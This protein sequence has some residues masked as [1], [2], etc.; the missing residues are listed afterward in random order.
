MRY[1]LPDDEAGMGATRAIRMTAMLC[2]AVLAGCG[3]AAQAPA[4]YGYGD[5]F[6]AG[7]D[8]MGGL[9]GG[10]PPSG[11]GGGYPS[12][13]EA[14]AAPAPTAEVYDEEGAPAY[15]PDAERV[16]MAESIDA[17]ASAPARESRRGRS[18]AQRSAAAPP[19]PAPSMAASTPAPAQPPAPPSD[20]SAPAGGPAT[21]EPEEPDEGEAADEGPMLIYEAALVL[22]TNEASERIDEVGRL[23]HEMGGFLVR[24]DDRSI[25]VRVPAG[26][27]REALAA[28]EALG[29]VLDRSVSALDVSEQVRDTRVRLQNAINL[30][31]R[32]LELLERAHTVPESLIIERELERLNETIELLRGALESL[33]ER[34]AYSTIT[35]EL[36]PI[37]ERL[38]VPREL[39]RLPFQWLEELGLQSLLTL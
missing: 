35:V 18:F 21:A 5:M 27:F 13:G 30:R 36:R 22:A 32:L 12:G 4:G 10:Y 33:E 6:T 14:Y 7:D 29:D 25:V 28:F 16:S 8:G 15:E 34:I 31:D 19:P 24:Q 9:G 23:T 37:E 17:P 38:E 11:G 20:P 39:F 26:R 2:V 1:H 3:G